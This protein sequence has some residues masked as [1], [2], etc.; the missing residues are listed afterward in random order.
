MILSFLRS[1]KSEKQIFS[2]FPMYYIGIVPP[3]QLYFPTTQEKIYLLSQDSLCNK[4]G[5]EQLINSG[6]S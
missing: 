3:Y 2:F 1:N 4:N 5:E 6:L